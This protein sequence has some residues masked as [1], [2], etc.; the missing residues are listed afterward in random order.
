M[1]CPD[2]VLMGRDNWYST[3][4]FNDLYIKSKDTPEAIKNRIAFVLKNI[5]IL[6]DFY[7]FKYIIK[8]GNVNYVLTFFLGLWNEFTDEIKHL[9]CFS[10]IYTYNLKN[11]KKMYMT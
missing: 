7:F 8:L 2:T 10:T 11:E 4:R 6:K 3:V 5:Q 9:F 1:V